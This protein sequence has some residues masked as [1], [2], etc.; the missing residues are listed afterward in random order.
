[1]SKKKS[2]FLILLAAGIM[3]LGAGLLARDLQQQN[4]QQQQKPTAAIQQKPATSKLP[5]AEL[6]I[7]NFAFNPKPGPNGSTLLGISFTVYN[8]STIGAENSPTAAGKLGWQANPS[9]NWQFEVRLEGRTLPSGAWQQ[10]GCVGTMA[11]PHVRQTFDWGDTV[12]LVKNLKREYR[13]WADFRDWIF[14]YDNNNNIKIATW[15]ITQ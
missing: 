7:E 15:P 1:M 4:I 14:E 6:L 13:V 11:G 5:K 8:D 10:L 2:V 12:P 3:V 9:L